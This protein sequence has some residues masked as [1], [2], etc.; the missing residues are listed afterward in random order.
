MAFYWVTVAL[1]RTTGTAI[2]DFLAESKTV[3]LGGH[4]NSLL[5]SMSGAATN[6]ALSGGEARELGW[7]ISAIL[8]GIVFVA[9]LVFWKTAPKAVLSPEAAD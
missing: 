4:A 7:L 5:N 3:D 9:V 2:G 8:S 6:A 1:C